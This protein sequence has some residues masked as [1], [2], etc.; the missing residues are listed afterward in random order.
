M[1]GEIADR[2]RTGRRLLARFGTAT[3]LLVQEHRAGEA[4]GLACVIPPV[5]WLMV[6]EAGPGRQLCTG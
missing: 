5:Q 6:M 3:L 2:M 4:V 1:P